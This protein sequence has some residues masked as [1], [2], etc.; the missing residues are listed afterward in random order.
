[1]I[2]V[3]AAIEHA[4]LG[5]II[6]RVITGAINWAKGRKEPTPEVVGLKLEELADRNLSP[7]IPPEN[8]QA[9]ISSVVELAKPTFEEI[10]RYSPNVHWVMAAVKKAAAKKAAT[11]KDAP[12]KAGKKGAKKRASVKK[13]APLRSPR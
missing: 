12:K 10:V 5:E 7:L 3:L 13:A 4:A 2:E 9:A 6:K 8:R 1:M 11:K